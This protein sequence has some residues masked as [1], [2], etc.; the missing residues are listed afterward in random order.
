MTKPVDKKLIEL[1]EEQ[2]ALEKEKAAIDNA[3]RHIA[4]IWP[5]SAVMGQK[6]AKAREKVRTKAMQNTDRQSATE[7]NT[8]LKPLG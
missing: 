1:I 3:I 7:I 5:D 6:N 4:A 2:I 8:N